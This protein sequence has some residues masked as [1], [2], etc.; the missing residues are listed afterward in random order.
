M[1]WKRRIIIFSIRLLVLLFTVTDGMCYCCLAFTSLV[2][3]LSPLVFVIVFTK[4]VLC[5]LKNVS[6][7]LCGLI[8]L[9]ADTLFMTV[10]NKLLTILACSYEPSSLSTVTTPMGH[11]LADPRVTCWEGEHA[12]RAT[13]AL[14]AFSYYIPLCVM[15]C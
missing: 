1:T 4:N 9:F 11:L 15:V 3:S 12:M 14:I 13:I 6:N 7:R 2:L 10:C 5:R 8:A